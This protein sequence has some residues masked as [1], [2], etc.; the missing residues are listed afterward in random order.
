MRKRPL[1]WVLSAVL[2]VQFFVP[3]VLAVDDVYLEDP[4]YYAEEWQGDQLYEEETLTFDSFSPRQL[5]DIEI[6]RCGVDVSSWQKNIDWTAVR[7]DGVEIAFIRVAYR[8]IT[9]GTL[10]QDSYYRKNIE[11]ALAAG[12]RVG[13]YVYSQAITVEEAVEEA[14]YILERIEG[15]NLS[16]PVVFDYEYGYVGNQ[17]GRL[18]SAKLTKAEATAICHAFCET[19]EA[20]GYQTAV[21]ANKYFL[22]TQLN[23][24]ELDSVWLAHYARKTDYTGDYDFWQCTSEGTVNGIL[25][26]TDLNFWFDDG[27]FHRVLPF[28]E[29]DV[30][31]WSYAGIRYAYEHGIINGTSENTFGPQDNATRGQIAAMLYRMKGSPAVTGS[32]TFTD[33]TDD[34]YRDAVAWAQRNG[35]IKGRTET[36]FEP[37]A[38]VTRQELVTMLYR[39]AGEPACSHDLSSFWD[40]GMIHDY[41][42]EAMAWAVKS[43]IIKGETETT[44]NP[45]GYATREQITTVLMRF[46]QVS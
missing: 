43:G 12:L 2:L 20:R 6:L 44:L 26:D 37:D 8:G 41:A 34:Y 5:D 24:G 36:T 3:S 9:A 35:V 11:G 19:V 21:Y 17:P 31:S 46:N 29:V 18:V 22:N 28:R 42:K 39:L 15:Y 32:A 13:V 33:L 25:G 30:G 4:L 16:L 10:Y 40:V 14:E 1:T 7:A 27:S 45:L 38:Y 23:A